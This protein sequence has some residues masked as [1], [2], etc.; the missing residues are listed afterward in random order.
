[1]RIPRARTHRRQSSVCPPTCARSRSRSSLPHDARPVAVARDR[2]TR[3]IDRDARQKTRTT[4]PSRAIVVVA[5]AECAVARPRSM[6]MKALKPSIDREGRRRRAARC[7][8]R[9]ARR[10]TRDARSERAGNERRADDARGVGRSYLCASDASRKG[11]REGEGRGVEA[12]RRPRCPNM[13]ET[14]FDE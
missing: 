14:V 11:G 9:R 10:A 3:A 1:M 4:E 8:R 7:P 13:R 6:V 2:S 12:A 5:V